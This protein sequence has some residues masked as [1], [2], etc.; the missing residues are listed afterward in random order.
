MLKQNLNWQ[1]LSDRV[2]SVM[3]IRKDNHMN[4]CL[5]GV[6]TETKTELLG[7]IESGTICY[8]N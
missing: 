5:G 1:E 4:D 3:K 8:Q 6:Y 7:P 2:Q